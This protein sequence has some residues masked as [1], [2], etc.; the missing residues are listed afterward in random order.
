VILDFTVGLELEF[1]VLTPD[2][3]TIANLA[4]GKFPQ[5]NYDIADLYSINFNQLLG[6]FEVYGY[7]IKRESGPGQLEVD[8]GPSKSVAEICNKID[9]FKDLAAKLAAIHGF[10]ISYH[11]KPLE[12]HPGSA[13]HV[14]LSSPLFDP[15]GIAANNGFV[16][17]KR[18]ADNDYVRWAIGGILTNV[19]ADLAVFLPSAASLKRIEPYLNAP[20]K[21]CWGRNNRSVL[22][23]VPDS[24]PKR[25]EHRLA[26]ADANPAAVMAAVM[27]A[28]AHGIENKIEPS[29]PIFGNAW[30]AVYVRE[31]II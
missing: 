11:P 14:H 6:D 24:K 13:I 25:I 30:D 8:F 27:N 9:I 4:S 10:E 5:K 2:G 26:G 31:A 19:K 17:A 3:F 22:M 21:I 28:A 7:N 18:D 1:Y 16:T 12:G 20:T 23:R 29:E 15:Y